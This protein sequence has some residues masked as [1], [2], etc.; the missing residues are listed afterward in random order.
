MKSVYQ[1]IAKV[2]KA[3]GSI[4]KNGEN[5]YQKYR[6]ATAADV[7]KKVQPLAM[8]AGLIMIR[9]EV[10]KEVYKGPE[11]DVLAIT[12]EYTIGSEETGETLPDKPKSTGTALLF[13]KRGT[14][15][16]KAANK[17]GTAADKYFFISL[18]KIPTVDADDADDCDG[19]GRFERGPRQTATVTPIVT[20]T[21]RAG[22]SA[23][24]TAARYRHKDEND[25]VSV[26]QQAQTASAPA[27]AAAGLIPLDASK[28]D[29]ITWIAAMI[30]A[31][32]KCQNNEQIDALVKV[33][34][35]NLKVLESGNNKAYLRIRNITE[36]RR[37]ASEKRDPLQQM[38]EGR[39][40]EASD[41]IPAD[42]D[43][44]PADD[45]YIESVDALFAAQA[46]VE[47]L[48]AI[49]ADNEREVAEKSRATRDRIAECYEAHIRRVKNAA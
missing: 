1:A 19:A 32:E 27:A 30:S 34:F 41:N 46:T 8:E 18:F 40:I 2:T 39:T 44:R 33:N 11:G 26:M 3:I 23:E 31:V 28:P 22:E 48:D 38:R 13:N 25:A 12:Y 14:P 6:Y 7:L 16:D 36:S 17:C 37:K 21:P 49:W 45:E 5:D 29:W 35:A 42:L 47:E 4:T 43:R 15:D 9:G 10:G 20:N 24:Q